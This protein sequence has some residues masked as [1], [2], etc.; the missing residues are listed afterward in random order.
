M[1]IS[2]FRKWLEL[3]VCFRV[4]SFKVENFI[5]VPR[6]MQNLSTLFWKWFERILQHLNCYKKNNAINRKYYTK[7]LD[8]FLLCNGLIHLRQII[9]LKYQFYRKNEAKKPSITL[10]VIPKKLA[11][12]KFKIKLATR[13][14]TLFKINVSAFVFRKQQQQYN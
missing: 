6:L 11:Q 14:A 2:I 3:A 4:K 13:I 8:I 10:I 5:S 1:T 12:E 9:N 7:P